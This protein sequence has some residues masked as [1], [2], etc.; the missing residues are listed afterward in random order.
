MSGPDLAFWQQRFDT[1]QLNWDRGMPS[2]QLAVWLADG[3]LAPGRV[4]VP[5]CGSGHEV[6]ALAA[7]GFAVTALDHAP[8][9]VALT[10]A[11]LAA[12]GLRAEVGTR[13]P[14]GSRH[15]R[16]CGLPRADKMRP[17]LRQ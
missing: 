15:P 4:V 7:A 8:G 5:G 2:P 11:R 17:S 16:V 3:S 13:S 10:Q 9:A 12:T 14:A 6:A 1:G